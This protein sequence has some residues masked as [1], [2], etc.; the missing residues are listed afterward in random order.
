MM[1]KKDLYEII[2]AR[3]DSAVD[4]LIRT[5]RIH[6]RKYSQINRL[7][8]EIEAYNSILIDMDYYGMLNDERGEKM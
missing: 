2:K 6:N 3:R 8:G 1:N 7:K 4:D 5:Y